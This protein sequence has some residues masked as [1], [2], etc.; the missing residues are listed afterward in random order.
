MMNVVNLC[1]SMIWYAVNNYTGIGPII[2]LDLSTE[3]HTQFLLPQDSVEAPIIKRES[4]WF[5]LVVSYSNSWM[6]LLVS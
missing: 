6:N 3:T 4:V 2:S 5:S 1:G